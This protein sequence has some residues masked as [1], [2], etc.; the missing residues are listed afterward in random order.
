MD[1]QLIERVRKYALG[2]ESSSRYE[3]SVRTAET[4]AMLC[5]RFGIDSSLGYFVG[6]AHD[7]C[8]E[9]NPRLLKTFAL[10]DGNPINDL[11]EKKNSLL[12][13][14]AAACMLESDFDITDSDILEAVRVHTFGE[15][16][17]CDLAKILYVADKIEPGRNHVTAE[18]KQMLLEKSLD[19][20]VLFV[21]KENIEYLESRG[22][23]VAPVSKKLL[24]SLEVF[25]ES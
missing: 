17:M 23:V 24:H 2:V 15:P 8:K 7:I 21:L 3:H 14:R 12:H 5:R 16:G 13:G 9:M 20:L 25:S 10:K 4:C 18:H 1:I 22:K 11:E 19:D 6:I